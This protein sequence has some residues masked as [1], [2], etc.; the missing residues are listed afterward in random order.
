[1]FFHPEQYL[2]CLGKQTLNFNRS[3]ERVLQEELGQSFSVKM[4]GCRL[5]LWA[6]EVELKVSGD[7]QRGETSTCCVSSG[8]GFVYS[9]RLW[10]KS[11]LIYS[12]R[13]S[14]TVKAGISLKSQDEESGALFSTIFLQCYADDDFSGI[15]FGLELR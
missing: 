14:S 8:L 2:D 15:I 5:V 3:L 6:Q 4:Y 7:S 9:I 12:V 10:Q 11:K 13:N 1:M